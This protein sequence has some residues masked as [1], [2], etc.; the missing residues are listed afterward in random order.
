LRSRQRRVHEP[1]S[2]LRTFHA[3][4]FASVPREG[5]RSEANRFRVVGYRRF[6]PTS[7]ARFDEHSRLFTLECNIIAFSGALARAL[8]AQPARAQ[9]D[10][11][12]RKRSSS[13][14]PLRSMRG[15][16]RPRIECK[17]HTTY[18]PRHRGRGRP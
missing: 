10:E 2:C 16:S 18:A 5:K 17:H 14:A 7:D 12:Y 15:R 1:Q 13:R 3:P 8:S 4:S 9:R 6:E 11:Y